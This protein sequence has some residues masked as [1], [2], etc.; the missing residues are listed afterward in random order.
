MIPLVPLTNPNVNLKW[1][2]KD[3]KTL[4]IIRKRNRKRKHKR[5]RDAN[6]KW[7]EKEANKR[8]IIHKRNRKDVKATKDNT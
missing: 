2:E 7:V 4:K 1:L 6:L 5:K 3:A 8:K